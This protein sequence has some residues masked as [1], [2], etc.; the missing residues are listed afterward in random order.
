MFRDWVETVTH[1]DE[2]EDVIH[3]GTDVNLHKAHDHSHL[4]KE[5]LE[6]DRR[7]SLRLAL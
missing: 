4:L 5:E 3:I 2:G 1:S 7:Q 6:E